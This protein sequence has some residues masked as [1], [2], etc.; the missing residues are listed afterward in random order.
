MKFLSMIR[1]VAVGYSH[2]QTE[3]ITVNIG[4]SKDAVRINADDFDEKTMKKVEDTGAGAS[5]DVNVTHQGQGGEVVTTAAPS[6]PNFGSPEEAP[7]PIDPV[8]NAV[9]PAGTTPD[10]LLVMKSTKGA[11]KGKYVI[12]DGMGVAITGDRAKHLGIDE[13]G[14]DTEEMASQVVST[15]EPK[16]AV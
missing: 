12:A 13:N 4:K 9:A 1:A 11:T 5:S 8:K 10:Q 15:T 6:A 16:P 7:L 3:T 14:Y 2:G